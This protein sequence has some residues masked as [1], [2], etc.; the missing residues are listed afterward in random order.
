MRRVRKLKPK[1]VLM[2]MLVNFEPKTL[3]F[4]FFFC[5]VLKVNWVKI[6]KD[7]NYVVRITKFD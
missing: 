5:Q 4:F 1:H 6:L 3:D 2:L 7:L